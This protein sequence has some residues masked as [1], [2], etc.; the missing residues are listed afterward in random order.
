[1]RALSR[2]LEEATAETSLSLRYRLTRQTAPTESSCM[3]M[4]GT[5]ASS[6]WGSR[7]CQDL[8]GAIDAQDGV[9]HVRAVDANADGE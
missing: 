2:A 8:A 6:W 4:F 5:S 9:L 1:L 3:G 7:Q